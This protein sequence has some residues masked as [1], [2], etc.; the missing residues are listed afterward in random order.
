MS[1]LALRPFMSKKLVAIIWLVAT[2]SI[3]NISI[4][5]KESHRQKGTV[6]LLRLAPADP[7]SLMQGDYMRLNFALAREILEQLPSETDSNSMRKRILVSDG[8]AVVT[9]DENNIAQLSRIETNTRQETSL[10][11]G[12]MRLRFRVRNNQ[13][14]FATNAFFFEEGSARNYNTARYGEFRVD[15]K[16]ELLLT[17]MR[18]A[19]L[20]LLGSQSNTQ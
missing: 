15:N 3:I 1:N 14:K 2:L 13:V 16:G 17:S 19:K 11:V 4:A 10:A 6:A 9:R 12:E 8:F 20:N 18:D 7:R 5:H